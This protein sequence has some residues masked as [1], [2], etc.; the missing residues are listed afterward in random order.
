MRVSIL[1]AG[2]VAFGMA[3]LLADAGHEPVALVALGPG[4]AG[5]GAGAPLVATGAVEA[6]AR[7]TSPRPARRRSPAPTRW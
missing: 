6:S 3:A 2:S 4:H 5:A 7:S 1:G